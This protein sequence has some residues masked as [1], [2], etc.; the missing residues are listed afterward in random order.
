MV[1]WEPM[2][3]HS[4]NINIDKVVKYVDNVGW[5]VGFYGISI[6]VGYLMPK[7]FL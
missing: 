4:S 3:D 1:Q 2:S 6:F 5:L 7:S